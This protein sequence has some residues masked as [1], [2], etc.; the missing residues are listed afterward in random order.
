MVKHNRRE[1]EEEETL[2]KD[3][4]YMD[5]Y[6]IRKNQELVILLYALF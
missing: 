6:Y 4:E 1:F 3:E 2:E 5:N